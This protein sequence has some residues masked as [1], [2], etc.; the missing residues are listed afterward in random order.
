MKSKQKSIVYKEKR[1]FDNI[2]K[3]CYGSCFIASKSRFRN[4][5]Q[6]VTHRNKR[7]ATELSK[8]VWQVKNQSVEPSIKRSIV[9][10]APS[11]HCGSDRCNLC[12]AEKLAI[13][14]RDRKLM[15]NK[16][17]KILIKCHD[18]KKL[19][20]KSIRFEGLMKV[21]VFRSITYAAFFVYFTFTT[22]RL[23]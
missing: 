6:S 22:Y 23:S 3:L 9:I 18:T 8:E 7:H 4:H 13:L 15:L 14:S 11:Y 1:S 5:K 10:A 12:L 21:S 16:R 17:L 2:N 19:K 20:L